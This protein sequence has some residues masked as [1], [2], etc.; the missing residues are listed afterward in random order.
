M[1]KIVL[2]SL[3]LFSV[4]ALRADGPVDWAQYGRYE[5]QNAVLDRPVE[6]G[7][8]GNSITDSWIRVDPDFFER[9][10]FLDR[11]IS[12]QTSVQM[13]ARFRSDVIDLKPQVVVILAGINDIARNNG[14]IELENVFGNIVSMCE[15]AKL[16]KIRPI[17]CS[18]LPAYRF[19]WRQEVPAADRIIELNGMIERYARENGI[20]YV[21]YHSALKDGRNGLPEKYSG[22]GV[23]PNPECYKIMEAIVLPVIDKKPAKKVAVRTGGAKKHSWDR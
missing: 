12:G 9:N 16:H 22:D 7:F 8:M 20:S 6:V 1:K 23:H 17:L 11:G 19:G 4:A 2:L 18:V 5:L 14:P 3:A 10:G 13:V 15:L 21:D